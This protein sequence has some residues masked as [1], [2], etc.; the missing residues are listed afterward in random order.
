MPV[1]FPVVRG[2]VLLQCYIPGVEAVTAKRG[3]Q[4]CV[5]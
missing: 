3:I 2:H 5:F 4:L 1:R